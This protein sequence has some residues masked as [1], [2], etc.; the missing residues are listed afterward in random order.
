MKL[1]TKYHGIKNYEEND[2]ITFE[3]GIPGFDNFKK[4]ILF[5]V[6]NNDVF[7]V[8]HSIENNE[9]GFL[10]VSPFDVD[11][12][13]EFNIDDDTI[14]Y[15]KIKEPSDA[16]VLSTVTLNSKVKD[17]TINLKAPIII[18]FHEKLGQQII[19]DNEKYEVKHKLI[20]N[21]Q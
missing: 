10:V 2:I 15:L 12:S 16:M 3:K 4:F 17:I 20:N 7:K 5:D 21:S 1:N 6:E 9:I 19:L 13:Y 8:L 14:Y 11:K 18:N